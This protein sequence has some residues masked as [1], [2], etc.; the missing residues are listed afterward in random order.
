MFKGSVYSCSFPPSEGRT[1]ENGADGVT[2]YVRITIFYTLF[3][4]AEKIEAVTDD[5]E[6]FQAFT[7]LIFMVS[8]PHLVVLNTRFKLASSFYITICR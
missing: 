8:T 6:T 4:I 5:A 7:N 2:W 3:I 1:S